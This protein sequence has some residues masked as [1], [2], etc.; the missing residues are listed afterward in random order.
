MALIIGSA[1]IVSFGIARIAHVNVKSLWSV[2]GSREPL[3]TVG[4]TLLPSFGLYLTFSYVEFFWDSCHL[5]TMEYK[6]G[7]RAFSNRIVHEKYLYK[8]YH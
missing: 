6:F 5:L 2:G 7:S 8:K 1:A 3:V 4:L